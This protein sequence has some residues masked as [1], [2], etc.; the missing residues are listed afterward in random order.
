MQGRERIKGKHVGD[1][2]QKQ[3]IE[4]EGK[5]RRAPTYVSSRPGDQP[6]PHQRTLKST[7]N[8]KRERRMEK[9]KQIIMWHELR[10]YLL[11]NEEMK[12]DAKTGR[13]R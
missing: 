5:E 1:S 4:M 10:S 6:E 3:Y 13:N 2:T 11:I 12:G 7:E 8:Y 9:P